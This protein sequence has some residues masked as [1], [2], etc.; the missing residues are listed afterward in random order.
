MKFSKRAKE[1]EQSP[2]LSLAETMR[3]LRSNGM[4]ITN[5]G[6]R[7]DVPSHVIDAAK[8]FLD[9]GK[10]CEYTDPRGLTDLRLAISKKL[11]RENGIEV[12]PD[13]EVVVTLGGKQA[14]FAALMAL[15]ETG[16]E[17][18]VE[19]PGWFCFKTIVSLTG[20]IPKPVKLHE[21]DSFLLNVEEINKQ[22]STKTKILMLCN[23]HNPTGS[24]HTRDNLEKIAKLVQKN[25]LIVIADECWQHL[26]YD[27]NKHISFA[28]LDGMRERTVT[29]NTTSKIYNMAGWRVGWAS[30]TKEIIEKITA[31]QA[32]SVTCPTSVAQ[33]GAIA[34]L[35]STTGMGDLSFD[36]LKGQYSGRRELVLEGI[37]KITGV[38]CIKPLGGI[39]MFPNFIK[40]G[41]TS[42]ILSSRLLLE[43][44]IG[45]VPGSEFG[46]NGEGHL[47]ILFTSPEE[48]IHRGLERMQKFFNTIN[49]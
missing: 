45:S 44:G 35:N 2:S 25:D 3:K 15:I 23:P 20:G 16:D 37:R 6:T 31:I 46:L 9:S 13:T 38:T 27:G 5:F 11:E 10:S 28:S 14:I 12:N 18:L 42:T 8:L 17:V 41:L 1:A 26:L 39:F 22:I 43:A 32:T 47:R 48:E 19:D 49:P 21:K 40:L 34:A 33:A 36:Q 4:E 29:V 24:V 7:P 30:G